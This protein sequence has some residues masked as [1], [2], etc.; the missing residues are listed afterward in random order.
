MP[1]M[2]SNSKGTERDPL[3]P[4][5]RRCGDKLQGTL[6]YHVQAP[7]DKP[8]RWVYCGCMRSIR[9]IL[10]GGHAVN[11]LGRNRMKHH[12]WADR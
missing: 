1:T 11:P 7:H 8:S 9:D 10:G 2:A 12:R 6:N 4:K 3:S 5:S